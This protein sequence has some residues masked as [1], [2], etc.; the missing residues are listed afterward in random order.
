MTTATVNIHEKIHS[1]VG[2]VKMPIQLRHIANRH[3]EMQDI[4][5]QV[6][7]GSN[8]IFI[9]KPTIIPKKLRHT[10]NGNPTIGIKVH[11]AV[12][13]PVNINGKELMNNTVMVHIH[14][15]YAR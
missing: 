3:A 5:K 13:I 12:I 9:I 11:G 2:I 4:I 7:I 6:V 14:A 15:K 1:S 10:N 8:R